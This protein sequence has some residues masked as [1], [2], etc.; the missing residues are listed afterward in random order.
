MS[1]SLSQEKQFLLSER[2][3]HL[4]NA[5]INFLLHLIKLAK[6]KENFFIILEGGIWEEEADLIN[7]CFI[8]FLMEEINP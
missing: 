5:I 7:L 8:R 4:R 6:L 2:E 1:V 3:P